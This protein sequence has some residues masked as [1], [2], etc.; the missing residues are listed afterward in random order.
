MAYFLDEAVPAD[1]VLWRERPASPAVETLQA[2]LIE[3]ADQY[4]TL[5]LLCDQPSRPDLPWQT[6]DSS[7]YNY[8]HA[9][10]LARRIAETIWV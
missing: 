1:L 2:R 4:R 3:I 5:E 9:S 6:A 7:T 10:R 8:T